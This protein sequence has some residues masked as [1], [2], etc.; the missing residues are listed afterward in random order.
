MERISVM[1]RMIVEGYD[2]DDDRWSIQ[3]VAK[4]LLFHT[5]FLKDFTQN[6][7]TWEYVGQVNKLRWR[8][9]G[10]YEY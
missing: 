4:K 9:T 7:S 5:R 2:G 1:V 6:K 8:Y 3:Y 10:L